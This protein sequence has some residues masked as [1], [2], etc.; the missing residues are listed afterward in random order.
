MAKRSESGWAIVGTHGIYTGWRQTRRDAIDD[1]VSDLYG[2]TGWDREL[3]EEQRSAWRK[4]RHNG[5]RAVKIK[6]TVQ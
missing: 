1:H 3:N 6:I 2:A 4:C 5:D